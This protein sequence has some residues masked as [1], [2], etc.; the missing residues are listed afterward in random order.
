MVWLPVSPL[1]QAILIP[2]WDPNLFISRYLLISFWK[3]KALNGDKNNYWRK[4][5]SPLQENWNWSILTFFQHQDNFE[6]AFL[7]LHTNYLT[8]KPAIAF[9]AVQKTQ[10]PTAKKKVIATVFHLS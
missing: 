6:S 5:V 9:Y 10:Q 2:L 8:Q 3:K 4:Q 7:S 1:Y